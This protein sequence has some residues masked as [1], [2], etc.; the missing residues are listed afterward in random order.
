MARRLIEAISLFGRLA[1]Y[2][3]IEDRDGMDD[4][5]DD[6]ER[7]ERTGIVPNEADFGGVQLDTWHDAARSLLT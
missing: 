3:G 6:D 5:G 4:Q 7:H 1:C 2:R